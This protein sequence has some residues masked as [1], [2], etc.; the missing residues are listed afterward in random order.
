MVFPV[1]KNLV[2]PIKKKKNEWNFLLIRLVLSISC[3]KKK[4]CEGFFMINQIYKRIYQ[5]KKK[6]F[7]I[8]EF[9]LF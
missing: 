3:Q 4:E 9:I 6:K 8:K 2:F 7:F 5:N 1:K